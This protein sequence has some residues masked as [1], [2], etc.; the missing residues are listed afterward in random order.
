M[1]T[2]Q[3]LNTK[4]LLYKGY[5]QALFIYLAFFWVSGQ[6]PSLTSLKTDAFFTQSLYIATLNFMPHRKESDVV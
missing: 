3:G 1:L 2:G 5:I 6:N 4:H